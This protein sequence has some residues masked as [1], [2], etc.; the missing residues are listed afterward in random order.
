[1]PTPG[2]LGKIRAAVAEAAA[3]LLARDTNEDTTAESLA[4]ELA[5]TVTEAMVDAYEAIQAKSY[6]MVVVAQFR[7]ETGAGPSYM[8]ALG[9][10]STRALV[11]AREAGE[12]FAWDYRTKRGNGAYALVPLV[13][14]ANEAWD[15]IREQTAPEPHVAKTSVTPGIEPS[16]EAMRFDIP[17]EV[18]A[19]ITADWGVD[20]EVLDK[21]YGPACLCGL[22]HMPERTSLGDPVTPGC[23]RHP[24][25][26]H[27]PGA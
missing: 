11:R 18:R 24:K 26:S 7:P 27:E 25:E 6:N 12:R 9:P 1:M 20:P 10:L 14:S 3:A 17:E 21:R 13:R 15:S 22:K 2:E 19:K 5:D 4:E 23:P 16:Y 8:A